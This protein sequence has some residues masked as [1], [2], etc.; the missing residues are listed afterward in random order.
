MDVVQAW[1][2]YEGVRFKPIVFDC[3]FTKGHSLSKP[4]KPARVYLH[5]V[6][7]DHL[8]LLSDKVRQVAFADAKNSASDIALL[9]PPILE[10]APYGRTPGGKRRN[11]ARQGL[12]DQDPE[13]IEFLESLTNPLTKT[14]ALESDIS[15]TKDDP[16]TITPL[17]QH[18]RDK[19]AAREKASPAK[20]AKGA[21][22]TVRTEVSKTKADEKTL[23][24]SAKPLTTEKKTVR[25]IRTEK[26]GKDGGKL[27]KKEQ[28]IPVT[29]P[30]TILK[31]VAEPPKPNGVGTER[32]PGAVQV[33]VAAAARMLQRDLGLQPRGGGSTRRGG[34]GAAEVKKAG[35]ESSNSASAAKAL[36]SKVVDV[37]ANKQQSGVTPPQDP[38]ENAKPGPATAPRT[39]ST[40]RPTPAPAQSKPATKAAALP[41]TAGL[42]I[43]Q[44]ASQPV[45]AP[46]ASL[47]T[48]TEAFL[49]H[50]NPSQGV[51]EPLIE[52]AMK[53]FGLINKV[54]IDKRKGFAYVEFAEPEG[55]RKA[56]AASPIKV[57]Q[58]H[59][60]V[61]ER[62]DRV[63]NR[64]AQIPAAQPKNNP[65]QPTNSRIAPATNNTT[66]PPAFRSGRGGRNRAGGGGG[67]L[68]RGTSST[69]SGPADSANVTAGQTAIGTSGP[70]PVP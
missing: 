36:S 23:G 21:K 3:A 41:T 49:K 65:M 9:G 44:P 60:Q 68:S 1:Q 51:T 42:Q 25:G 70:R 54:E 33:P 48:A 15:R 20:A 58:S 10:F 26:S 32:R 40:K 64:V 28:Q 59:V 19:K 35:L 50:A 62:K 7:Q 39:D 24:L 38:N 30:P 53:V 37:T 17:I 8:G 57:A 47:S 4:S 55:L 61:L 11:D 43:R 18:L 31:A 22:D 12:I 34:R 2:G 13:F 6:H 16:V 29:L 63:S 46:A 45:H 66:T 27:V 56:I 14:V 67:G 69:S 52:E 5:L